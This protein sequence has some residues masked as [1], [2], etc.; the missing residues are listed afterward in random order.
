MGSYIQTE[1]FP[2]QDWSWEVTA[3]SDFGI[4]VDFP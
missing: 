3:S 4:H 1:W 2:G